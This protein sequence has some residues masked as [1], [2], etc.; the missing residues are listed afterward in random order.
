M[1]TLVD[2]LENDTGQPK[3]KNVAGAIRTPFHEGA[4]LEIFSFVQGY[5]YGLSSIVPVSKA[6]YR[7]AIAA[8]SGSKRVENNARRGSPKRTEPIANSRWQREGRSGSGDATRLERLSGGR[9][10]AFCQLLKAVSSARCP[11]RYRHFAQGPS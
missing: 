4:P 7:S 1:H 8:A 3:W 9:E 6:G 2:A 10:S 11:R 5:V